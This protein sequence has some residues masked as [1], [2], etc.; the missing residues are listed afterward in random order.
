MCPRLY[1]WFLDFQKTWNTTNC[2]QAPIEVK[3]S[4]IIPA[5]N[6]ACNLPNLLHPLKIQTLEPFEI[7]VVDDFSE[8]ETKEIAESYGVTVI[9]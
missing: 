6:E 2:D 3:L 8:D 1:V 9:T 5:R 7:I 4:I